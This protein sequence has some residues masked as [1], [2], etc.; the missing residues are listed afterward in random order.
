M[1][2]DVDDF[3]R[4]VF[5]PASGLA[6][7]LTAPVVANGR[8][9]SQGQ[10]DAWNFAALKGQPLAVE[11]RRTLGLAARRRALVIKDASGK[12]LAKADDLPG[13]S[14]D[15]ELSFNPPADGVYTAEI[16]ERFRS[17]GG[18]DFTSSAENCPSSARFSVDASDRHSRSPYRR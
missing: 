18:P 11:V 3:P 1:L 17:R 16:R 13:G 12:E 5:Q 9:S 4:E 2:F 6:A 8:I 10:I 15:C 7:S 14:P